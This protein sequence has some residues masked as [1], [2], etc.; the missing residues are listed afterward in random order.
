MRTSTTQAAVFQ[1]WDS[2]RSQRQACM[3]MSEA[4]WLAALSANLLSAKTLSAKT[5][6]ANALSAKKKSLGNITKFQFRQNTH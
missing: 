5:L 1:S 3:L 2:Q 4:W 6:S